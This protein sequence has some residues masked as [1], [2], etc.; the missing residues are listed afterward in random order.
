MGKL[1]RCTVGHYAG[2]IMW[3]DDESAVRALDA[4]TAQDPE[5]AWDGPGGASEAPPPEPTSDPGI[6][7]EGEDM[8]ALDTESEPGR[9]DDDD[10]GAE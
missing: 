6:A 10:E 7:P 2:R 3:Y 5:A 9:D 8:D 4:G 1:L